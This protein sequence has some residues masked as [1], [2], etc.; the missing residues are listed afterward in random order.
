MY[1]ARNIQSK[2]DQKGEGFGRRKRR[3]EKRQKRKSQRKEKIKSAEAE[4]SWIIAGFSVL[5]GELSSGSGPARAGD[6]KR[7]QLENEKGER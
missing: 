1:K 4:E 5:T 7:S 2:A 3:K 6:H